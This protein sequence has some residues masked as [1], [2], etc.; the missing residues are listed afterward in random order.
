VDMENDTVNRTPELCAC[1]IGSDAG[2]PRGSAST[3]PFFSL[4][5]PTVQRKVLVLLLLPFPAS[6]VVMANLPL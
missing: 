6:F 5:R 3:A 2:K 1:A 4:F